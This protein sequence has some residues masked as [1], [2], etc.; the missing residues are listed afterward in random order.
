[1]YPELKPADRIKQLE[2]LVAVLLGAMPLEIRRELV[3]QGKVPAI[4]TGATAYDDKLLADY[5]D[6]LRHG[7]QLDLRE[8]A[9]LSGISLK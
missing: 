1:M 3:R 9:I 8:K 2:G 5:Q 6:V 7:M 4:F